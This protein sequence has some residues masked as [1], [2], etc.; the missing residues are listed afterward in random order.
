MIGFSF[1]FSR[2]IAMVIKELIQLRRDRLTFAMIIGIP[3]LEL[4]V[5]GY[6]VN[7]DPRYLPTAVVS[8]DSSI[9]TRSLISGLKNSDYFQFLDHVK[10][11]AG[12]T[13]SLKNG[14]ALFVVTI[15]EDFTRKML[16]G[17][18]PSILVEA[19]ASDPMAT[20]GATASLGNLVQAIL[21]RDFRGPLADMIPKA[22]P[23]SIVTHDLYNPE[24]LTSYNVV[25]GL[26]GVV[27]TFTL[28]MMTALAITR[29]RERGTMENLLT[30]PVTPLEVICGKIVPYIFI[31]IIQASIIMLSAKLLFHVPFV[32]SLPILL[33]M[34]LLFIVGN[35]MIGITLSSFANNQMQ[36][37]QMAIFT[38][39]PSILLSGFLFPFLGMPMWAQRIGSVIPLTYF[40]RIAR[41]I[42]LKGSTYVDLW[43]NMWPLL[44]FALVMLILGIRFYRRTLD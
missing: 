37:M 1:S 8:A 44:V 7:T 16:R 15:P 6:A 40:M 26:M 18:Q 38:L 39:L 12:G 31:G 35:L 17:E 10:D 43:P 29:E 36:A 30:M 2:W 5:F 24:A 28:I 21:T 33:A 14:E 22:P 23:Y 9:F 32:G 41:G 19:D 42:M 11:E 13:R 3:I 4:V 20:G 25:P 34:I 27:L